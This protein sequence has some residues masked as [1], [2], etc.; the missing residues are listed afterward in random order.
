MILFSVIVGHQG[1]Q[2]C[3]H[4]SPTRHDTNTHDTNKCNQKI[5]IPAVNKPQINY[6]F[7][8]HFIVVVQKEIK[9]QGPSGMVPHAMY[10][11]NHLQPF[12][13]ITVTTSTTNPQ[14]PCSP[15]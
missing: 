7:S 4:L 3:C 9:S 8:F 10:I 6:H 14:P 5:G 12:A 15:K 13:P 1:A 2:H 11:C